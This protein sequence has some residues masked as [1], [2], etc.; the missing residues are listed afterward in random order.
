MSISACKKTRW[1]ISVPLAIIA[2][3]CSTMP[4]EYEM[5]V[6]HIA[7]MTPKEMAIFEQRFN[8]KLRIQNPNDVEFSIN[9]L[10]FDIEL[11]ERAFANG[12]SGQRVMVPR[13]G[14]EVVETEVF[15]TLGSF[16]R[17]VEKLH[18]AG[19]Q[20]VRYRLK[21]T[22]FVDAPGTFKAPF[23]ESGEIDLNLEDLGGDVE[24]VQ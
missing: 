23:D 22:A 3:S 4:K 10:R 1:W 15:T 6:V 2:A 9:G 20:K 19:G 18:K 5:L 8:I 16:L 12:M 24:K 17:Q 7:N 14:S 11:N 21:G 13:F